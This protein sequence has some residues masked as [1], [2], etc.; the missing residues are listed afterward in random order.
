[1]TLK[2][3]F[4]QVSTELSSAAT[5]GGLSEEGES[6]DTTWTATAVL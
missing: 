2:V 3:L 5:P 4:L 6:T 1:M